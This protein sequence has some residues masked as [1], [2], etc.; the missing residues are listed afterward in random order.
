MLT[1]GIDIDD[2]IT[3]SN[4]VVKKYINK[5]SN[6]EEL[7]NNVANIIRGL[8][9]SDESKVF[10]K[11]YSKIMGDSIKVKKNAKEIINKLYD[12]GNRI[13]IVTARNNNYYDDA[14]GFSYDYLKRNGIKFH[15]LYVDQAYKLKL[16]KEENV[17]LFIDDSVDI[18]DELYD[19]NIKTLLFISSINKDKKTKSKKVNN[20]LQ[21]YDYIKRIN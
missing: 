16:C 7:K 13:V 3:N 15:E 18:I 14:Y 1:I 12:E 5:Y 4:K 10:Y 6:S 19:N 20:W 11:K 9:V 2:T 17:D 8:Y 21:I